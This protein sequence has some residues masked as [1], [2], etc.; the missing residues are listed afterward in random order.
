MSEKNQFLGNKYLKIT[1]SYCTEIK[2]SCALYAHKVG[3]YTAVNPPL[4]YLLDLAVL[5]I[6]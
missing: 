1:G 4:F 6:T 5:Y 2:F 3:K